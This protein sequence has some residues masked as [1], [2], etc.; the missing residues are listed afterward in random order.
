V[1]DPIASAAWSGDGR[2]GSTVEDL[3]S[4]AAAALADLRLL[5][6]SVAW[7][8]LDR[9]REQVS[10]LSAAQVSRLVHEASERAVAALLKRL[11]DYRGQSRFEVWAAKFAIHE[12]AVAA[13]RHSDANAP[14]RR[15]IGA[16][17]EVIERC[18]HSSR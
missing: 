2:R 9:R 7:F 18:L 5:L 14:H 1:A 13:R 8:E 15:K 4:G 16:R 11:G 10:G 6:I 17:E 3:R 12:T